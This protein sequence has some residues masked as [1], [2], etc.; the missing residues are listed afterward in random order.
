VGVTSRAA[1]AGRPA[2]DPGC[3]GCPQLGTLRALR[4]AG[5]EPRGGLWCE[6]ADAHR[7]AGG[8]FAVVDGAARALLDDPVGRLREAGRAGARLVVVADRPGPA[9]DAVEEALRA[10]DVT[11]ARL[12]PERLHEAEALVGRLAATPGPAALLA[13]SPCARGRPPAP[14]LAVADA[15]CN[16]CGACLA[17]AC[18]AI[19]DAGGEAMVIDP[20]VCTGCGLCTHLCRARAIGPA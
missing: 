15:R 20:A 9:A 4:R 18:P 16:R 5:L 19:S 13:L 11:V 17:L 3:A 6:P 14:P 10:G 12:A 2:T 7:G 1:A 8:P